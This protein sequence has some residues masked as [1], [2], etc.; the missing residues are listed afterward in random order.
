M[1]PQ[2][3]R[4]YVSPQGR[5]VRVKVKVVRVRL[6]TTLNT[7][8]HPNSGVSHCMAMW[9]VGMAW[10]YVHAENV[11]GMDTLFSI[12]FYKVKTNSLLSSV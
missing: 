9:V 4:R 6:G 12:L 1:N 10:H 11:P 7:L 8:Y 3:W 2:E 5:K